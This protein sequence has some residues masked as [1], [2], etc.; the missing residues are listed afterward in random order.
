MPAQT[1]GVW[2]HCPQE[3]PGCKQ[4]NVNGRLHREAY[5][6]TR[7]AKLS[8]KQTAVIRGSLNNC[9]VSEYIS[10]NTD[11]SNLK[12]AEPYLVKVWDLYALRM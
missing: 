6:V 8:K 7:F 10:H 12:E 4:G 2:D 5:S 9:S 1:Q 11:A 3:L